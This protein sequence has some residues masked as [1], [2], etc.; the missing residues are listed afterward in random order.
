MRK[1]L[2][3]VALALAALLVLLTAALW[4]LLGSAGGLRFALAQAQHFTDGAL[5]VQ[6]AEGRLIGPLKLSG[7]RYADG[8]GLDAKVAQAELDL[9]IWPLLRK[10]VHVLNLQVEGVDVALPK[11][12][13]EEPESQ[14]SFSLKPPIDLQLDRV[15]VGKVR[16]TQ[17]QDDH[18][19]QPLFLSDNLDLAGQWTAKGIGLHK[20]TLRAPDGHADLNGELAI[21]TDEKGDGALGFGWKVAGVDY[22]GDIE[23]HGDGKQVKVGLK[24]SQPMAAQIDLDLTQSGEYPWTAKVALPAFDP[25]PL[26]GD[27]ALKTLALDIQGSGNRHGGNVNGQVGINQYQLQLKPLRAHFS[28]DFKLLTLDELNLGSPQIKGALSASGTV[29]LGAQPVSADLAL[30]WKDVLLPANLV[31]QD[32]ASRGDITVKGSAEQ[33][34][35][36]G[37][38]DIGPPGNLA[39]LALNLDGTQKQINLHTLELKQPRGHLLAKGTLDLQPALAWQMQLTSENLNP[40]QLLAGWDGALNMDLVT[41]GTL[42]K[43]QPDATVEIRKLEGKLRDRA[44]KGSGKLHVSP[45]QVVDGK[46]ELASGGS[47]VDIAAKPGTSNDIDLTLAIASLG[48]WL[49]EAAGKLNGDFRVRGKLPKLAIDGR[50]NGTAVTYAGQQI[51]KLQLTADVPD[52][53]NP[54]GKLDLTTQGVTAGGFVFRE[55]DL[56]GNGTSAQHSLTLDARGDQLSTGLSLSGTLK[57][58]NWNGTLSR[59]D[60]EP[61]GIPRWRLQQPTKLGYNDGALNLSEL[62]LTAGAPQLCA[63]AKQDKAGNLDASYR[64]HDLP[65]ALLTSIA[66]SSDLPM[67][68]DGVLNGNGAIRRNAAGALSGNATIS[69]TRGTVTYVEH[70][71]RPLLSYT[72]LALNAELSPTSQHATLSANFNDGGRLDGQVAINGAQQNLSGQINLRFNDLSLIELF[73]NEIASVKGRLNGQFHLGGTV[74]EPA[75]TGQ[76]DV[77]DFAAEVPVAGLKLTQGKLTVSTTDAQ[78]FQI[79]GGVQSGKGALA[80]DGYAGIGQ[81]AQTALTIKGSQF[82][83]ADIPA[84]KVVISPDLVIKQDAKG[85]DVG[86]S[87]LLESADVDVS[88]LPG[89]GATQASPDVVVVDE[90]KQQEEAAKM[91][92]TAQIK[93]DL[94]RKT[95]LVGMGLDGRLSGVLN[96][97]ERPGRATTGQGQ[98]TVDGIYK[99]YGQNL[100]IEQGRLLFASTPIDNPGLDIRAARKLSPNATIDDGQKVGLYVSGTAQRPVLTVFSNPVMEQS[101]ALSYLI[102]G[103]PLS[104][105]KGGE[106]SMVG[107]AAQ[108]LGSA[109][110]D[111]LAKSIGSKIGVDDIGVSSNEALGGT[112]AFTVGKYLSPRLY[113]SYG[114]GLFE[115]GQVITLRYRLSHRWNFEAQNATDFSR[116][117]LNYRIEK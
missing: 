32:L 54:G 11:P 110:G 1:W 72:D 76:A 31:G 20:L 99:A 64:L 116:A 89:A 5:T 70:A 19:Q 84:A 75:I 61:K 91:P 51:E 23:A 6:H 93:V 85:I 47:T 115:P 56:H 26:L 9:R 36:E 83:A 109:A 40:G 16:I 101:D 77:E 112:S 95:H 39:K 3:R 100:N 38:V 92:I 113:L 27:S 108:A 25:K 57:G 41:Q 104:Q 59:F 86:G 117:S 62:C 28:D 97:S 13:P 111:L 60:L 88:K 106:G 21:S 4:W 102:T 103:K 42:P 2:K 46:L 98:I 71:D 37:D 15:H 69:S 63:A 73:T 14:S 22:A 87:V 44:I 45:T 29:Q 30:H 49:P 24:L 81:N 50:L 90:K 8:S 34:H 7:L 66:G 12:A 68:A 35:T 67:R 53:S 80:I 74:K 10:R 105:V 48:D 55:V 107:A 52:I 17:A 94:G 33:F 18:Q 82:T 114:V 43:D 96:V 78:R 65:L 58:S 79:Q